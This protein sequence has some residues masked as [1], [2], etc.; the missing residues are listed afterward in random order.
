MDPKFGFCNRS[1]RGA[2]DGVNAMLNYGYGIL[3]GFIWRSVHLAALD[4]YA[5]YLHA[6]LWGRVSLVF[7][8]I[9]EFRQQVVDR[10][11]LS[12]VNRGKVKISEFE[13]VDGMCRMS[14]KVR[15]L[16]IASTLDR[17]DSKMKVEGNNISWD[18]LINHQTRLL[19][20]NLVGKSDYNG[21]Y[22]RW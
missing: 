6:Y 22:R 2:T 17:L 12:M 15:R 18:G 8:I 5:G 16:L 19:A 14:D 3:R 4:P 13:M 7:D 9:E 10:T 1:G 21:F 20:T 11:V